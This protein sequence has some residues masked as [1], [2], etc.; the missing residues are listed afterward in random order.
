[1]AP[2]A[3][4]RPGATLATMSET[5]EAIAVVYLRGAGI[6]IGALHQPLRVPSHVVVKYVDRMS[7]ADLRRQYAELAD[8]P[9]VEP[10]IIDNGETLATLPDA[11]EDFIVANH[12]LEHCQDP[13]RTLQNL[14]RV[15]KPGG[16]LYM[17]VPDKRLTFDAARPCTTIEH[18]MRDYAEG[19]AWS[20]RAHF[21]EW[22]RLVNKRTDDALVD[23]EIRHLQNI[24]YSIHFHVWDAPHLLGFLAALRQF[25]EFELEVFIRNGLESIFVL[26]RLS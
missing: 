25:V 8:L 13:F 4:C 1:M 22:S 20:R 3:A 7:A 2:L 21:E 9:L 10:D 26:R 18:L 24:D 19:P 16:V 15:V 17:V 6:E 11:S 5:R 14:F 12:F 23:D